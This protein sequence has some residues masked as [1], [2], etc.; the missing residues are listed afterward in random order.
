MKK[1]KIAIISEDIAIQ[2]ALSKSLNSNN[3][4]VLGIFRSAAEACENFKSNFCEI[5]LILASFK[6]VEELLVINDFKKEFKCSPP[7]I[8]VGHLLEEETIIKCFELGAVN[9]VNNKKY[10]PE[11]LKA[12]NDAHNGKP[13]IHASAANVIRNS[14]ILGQ[15]TSSEKRIYKLKLKGLT[16]AEIADRLY[17]SPNTI[18]N[19]I[20]SIRK[21]LQ[22][23]ID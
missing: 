16:N 14:L 13:S 22:H 1:I 20:K 10:Y 3:L 4:L 6:N 7:V 17:N 19:H 21:K 8:I 12:I 9:L 15:L 11:L 5:E 18:R 2:E 23:F